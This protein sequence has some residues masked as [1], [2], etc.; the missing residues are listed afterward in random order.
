MAVATGQASVVVAWRA[1]KRGA[2]TSRPWAG[3]PAAA[4]QLP[5]R[6]TRPYGLLRPV[7]E[8]AMLARRYMHE[9]GA[10]RDHLAEV[11]V[12]LRAARQPEP[13]SPAA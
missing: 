9:Y 8:V 11:A 2:R 10:T 5:A 6:W 4:L 7:D 1:R 3:A 12:A 13:R